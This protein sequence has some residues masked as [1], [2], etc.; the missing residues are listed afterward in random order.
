MAT[1]THLITAE[2]YARLPDRGVPTELVRGEVIEMNM[3]FPRHGQ[4]CLA[5][6][7]LVRSFARTHQLGHVV[8]NDAGIVTERNPD[9]VRGG[10]VWFVS[11]R[12][13]PKGPLPSNYLP[14]PPDIVF[15]ILSE[16]DR[17]SNVYAKVSEYLAVGVPVVCVVDPRD[18]TVR[19]YFPEAPEVVLTAAD[20]LTFPN[21]LPG[22][23]VLV[24]RLFE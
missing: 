1:A 3:P 17:W 12:K 2:E 9:T 13:V 23:S 19:L 4:V 18:E 20:E 16:H 22:F 10:D 5:V 24:Q 7:E 8:C 14:V 6:G 11:Y 15:E 21:Q